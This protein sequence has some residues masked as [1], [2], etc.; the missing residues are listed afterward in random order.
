[1]RNEGALGF[2]RRDSVS[3]L[4]I[5]VLRATFALFFSFF[6]FFFC[7]CVC[8]CACARRYVS[9]MEA[10]RLCADDSGTSAWHDLPEESYERVVALARA[11]RQ[12]LTETE[13]NCGTAHAFDREE[14]IDSLLKEEAMRRCRIVKK[15]Q[16][17]MGIVVRLWTQRSIAFANELRTIREKELRMEKAKKQRIL[18]EEQL[19]RE[20]F[21][22]FW[23]KR[24]KEQLRNLP[25]H[26]DRVL[27]NAYRHNTLPFATDPV[28]CWERGIVV[29]PELQ[30]T[31]VLLDSEGSVLL[32]AFHELSMRLRTAYHRYRAQ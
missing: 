19:Y 23:E 22:D 28:D 26:P 15:E 10:H 9:E 7:V 5:K 17:A 1:M 32:P 13:Q 27:M 18:L 24:K 6:F 25:I 3:C 14:Y 16:D 12:R 4:F 31:V 8:E 30:Q 2:S 11:Y 29:P 20:Q 21:L